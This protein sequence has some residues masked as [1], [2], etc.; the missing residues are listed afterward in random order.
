MKLPDLAVRNHPF[1]LTLFFLLAVFGTYAYLNMPRT[2][3][4]S[5]YV[6]GGS[7]LVVYPGATPADMEQLVALPLE[8]SVNQLDDI[9]RIQTELRDGIAIIS[10]EFSYG[11]DAKEK[12]NEFVRQVNN[13]RPQLPEGI[14]RLEMIEWTSSDVA[15]M[16][17]ALFTDEAEYRDM[18][19]YADELKKMIERVPGVKFAEVVAAPGEEIH[20]KVDPRKMALL[21]ISFDHIENAISSGNLNIPGGDL[22]IQ[23]K[24]YTI[25]TSGSYRDLEEIRN[26]VVQ[27]RQGNIIHLRDIADVERGYEE[28]EHIARYNGHK[29]VFLTI[30]QKD[31]ENLF[32]LN[33]VLKPILNNFHSRLP[34]NISMEPVFD[35]S[36]WVRHRIG[37]F[38]SNLLQG[39][40]LVGLVIFL[41][42]GV[43]SALVV[44]LAIP[45]S[46]LIGLGFVDLSGYGLQQ[47][48]IAGLV[49]SLGL[50]VDNSIVVI[51]NINRFIA[52]GLPP[53]EAS[54][55]ATQQIAWPVITATLTTI[56]AF[57]PI[58]TMP[59]KAG[60]F[61]RS[62]PLT[63]LFTLTVS[64]LIALTLNPLI[65]AFLFRGPRKGE[66]QRRNIFRALLDRLVDGPYGKLL[67]WS[68][69]HKTAVLSI[70]GIVFAG[71]LG[72]FPVIGLS[73]FPPA[74][75]PEFMIR[76][77]LPEASSIE[78]TDAAV[79]RVEALLDTARWVDRYASNIGH[80][81][82]RIYY[83]IFPR[84]YAPNFGE[85]YVHLRG[86]E[87]QRYTETVNALRNVFDTAT[88]ADVFIK[89]YEQGV[90]VEAPVMIYVYGNEMNRLKTIAAD[91]ERMVREAPGAINVENR[92]KRNR[93]D[94]RFR[95]NHDKAMTLGV[96]IVNI[97]KTIRTVMNGIIISDFRSESGK[98]YPIRLQTVETGSMTL[99]GLDNIYVT[100]LAGATVPLKQLVDVE[101][102]NVPGIITRLNMQRSIL[103]SADLAR[104]ASLD[105]VMNPVL[106][107]LAQYR[108]P[109]GYG[110]QIA[111]EL[112]NRNES[113]GGM[114]E[115]A[116]I[117]LIAIFAVLVLQFRSF[118]QPLVIFVAV[119]LAIIGS[120]WALFLTGYSFSFTAFI[121]LISLIGIVVNN[122]IILVDYANIL[123]REGKNKTEAAL[124]AG[125]V[126]FTPII[127][128]ALT[129]IGGLLP[130][131]LRGG[132]IWAPLGWTMIGGLLASTLLTLVVV[133]ILYSM[134]TLKNRS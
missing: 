60:D 38:T 68:M 82:P 95:I 53:R 6:P 109:V 51:E 112:E 130:L 40:L 71:S 29:A 13:T 17:L 7:V 99:S 106:E 91:I 44:V 87:R 125:R 24:N 61:I 105:D 25:Q 78:K 11:T 88:F 22:T 52:R 76:V 5:V 110:Y 10:V 56:L 32:R 101:F 15:I 54:V 114:A 36:V 30:M 27:N 69:N 55:R 67:R 3:N 65:T 90:P 96:P 84:N 102:R 31:N 133:P 62:L 72:L 57:I 79:K 37:G 14:S 127:L 43:R 123:M 86:Y 104:D 75:T 118:R 108:F 98:H 19:Y 116:V 28:Q 4:P 74:E 41:A 64:L 1:T 39:I 63:I 42:I 117:A 66:K 131:T 132:L 129:T 77:N 59:D 85:I 122:S 120:L 8:E 94:L 126:R 58:I 124:E 121:G 26:V 134:I 92:V 80:G 23:G 12:Y 115:A 35:Q 70:A 83:N 103:I 100:S 9:E 50:L 73:F 93:T 111:G 34:D 113:F 21:H 48:S 18:V 47:I 2:E 20:I 33:K 97:D 46:L 49:V 81:N 45:L 128:T 119:P 89:E 16:Q 107:H